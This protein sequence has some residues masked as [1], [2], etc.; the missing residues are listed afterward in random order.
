MGRFVSGPFLCSLLRQ[1]PYPKTLAGLVPFAASVYMVAADPLIG[2]HSPGAL[3]VIVA[4]PAAG[5]HGSGSARPVPVASHLVPSHSHS[6][7]ALE[8]VPGAPLLKPTG[9]HSARSGEIVPR[10]ANFQP[11]RLHPARTIEVI[12]GA[13]YKLPPVARIR[14]VMVPIPPPPPRL[15][16]NPQRLCR[17]RLRGCRR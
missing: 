10:S 17:C 15:L 11:A 4:N 1:S 16:P 5:A 9:L 12:P 14:A 6:P 8:V 3:Q 7:R 2:R 13:V